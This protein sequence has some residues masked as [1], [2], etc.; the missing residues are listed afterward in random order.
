MDDT[1]KILK[2]WVTFAGCVLVVVV[3]YWA[4]AIFVPFALAILLTFVLTPPVTALERWVGRVSAVLIV[5]TLVF[6]VLGLAGWVVVRQM[7][8]LAEDLPAYRRNLRTKIEDVRGAGKGGTVEKLQETIEDIKTDLGTPEAPKR[9][10]S[11]TVVV[12]SDQNSRYAGFAWLGPIV[13]PLGTAGL[14]LVTVI[15]MLL[16]RRDLRDR[17]IG[18][19]GHGQ[20]AATTKA[21]DEAGTRVSRQLL[22]Q[23]LVNLVYGVAVG[24]GL[25][26]LAV[27]YPLL[28]AAL[29]GALRFI[30]YVGPVLGA[31]APIV[32]SLAALEGW[33][34]PL[35]VMALFVVLEL[36]TNLVLETVLYAGAAGVS[37]VALLMS[38]AFWTWLWGPLGLLMATPLTVCL[39]VLGKHVPGL[40]FVGI[41][42]ADAPALAPEHGYYQRLL[43]RDQGEAADLIDQFIRTESP[44]SVYDVLLLPALN[45]AERDRLEE[46]LSQDEEL[47]VIETTR[48]LL[49]DAA[50]SI[51]RMQPQLPP[52]E[53][54]SQDSEPREPLRVLGYASNGVAD[55]LALAMLAH[56]L[57]D[58]PISVEITTTRML[59]TELV[60]L[61]QGRGVS[62]VCLA[63]LPPS[64]S[65]K[66]RYLVKR[67]RAA[68]PELRILVGRWAPPTLADESTQALREAGANHVA[69]T[70]AQT[71]EYL[72][73]LEEIARMPVPRAAEPR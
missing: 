65:S 70:L 3:L 14:V 5:V 39:V 29:G 63:D 52:E 32:V 17:L 47:V 58:L 44:R 53:A 26:V 42:M 35:E 30:P 34:G 21:F 28:W 73:G 36:F 2:P 71:R 68:S 57:D 55:E 9:T 19:I 12:T 31:G 24:L 33:T 50:D 60:A 37:Q 61:V 8:N 45:Y 6:T 15:F 18:L 62:V 54:I 51:R 27:P 23:S 1:A 4:H 22:M 64:P 72:G 67:L 40:E 38:V 43:A 69:S 59:A 20:L 13:G 10:S 66:T 56:L 48:E 16:E 25:Y 46:R 11:R 49:S 7:E 41:L